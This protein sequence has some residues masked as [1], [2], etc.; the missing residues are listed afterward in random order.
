MAE[1]PKKISELSSITDVSDKDLLI[2]SDYDH[3][4]VSPISKKMEI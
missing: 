3:D 4:A 1:I 2:V